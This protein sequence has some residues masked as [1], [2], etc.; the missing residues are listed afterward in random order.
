MLWLVDGKAAAGG[1]HSVRCNGTQGFCVGQTA[2]HI[3]VTVPVLGTLKWQSGPTERDSVVTS[4]HS[5]G[6]LSLR[7]S[8]GT[9]FAHLC[10]A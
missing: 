5:E 9:H 10:P 4:R 8:L 6:T 2:V 1:G 7:F 3:R